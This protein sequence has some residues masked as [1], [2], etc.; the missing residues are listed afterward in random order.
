MH[1]KTATFLLILIILGFIALSGVVGAQ[2][3]ETLRVALYPYVPD[4]RSLFFKL[5]A[6]FEASHPGVNL[7]LVESKPLVDD[8]YDGGLL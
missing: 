1:T 3:P 4:G 8:Y 7:E 2:S 6:A 5:E